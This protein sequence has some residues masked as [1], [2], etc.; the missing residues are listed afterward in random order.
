V[1]EIATICEKYDLSA[2]LLP[3]APQWMEVMPLEETNRLFASWAFQRDM[4]FSEAYRSL[5]RECEIEADSI[6][7]PGGTNLKKVENIPLRVS[8][9]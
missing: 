4:S 8:D 2:A 6:Y 5:V 7:T 3:W 9:K 1:V